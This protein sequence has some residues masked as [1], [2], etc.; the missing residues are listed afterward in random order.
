MQDHQLFAKFSKCD[1]FKDKIQYLGHVVTKEGI[2]VDPKK[3]RAIKDVTDVL[4]FMGITGYYRRF[5]EGFSRIANSI[6]S[7]QKKG[8]KFEWNQKCEESFK[9]LKTLLTN[10]PILRIADPNKEFL[11]STDAYNDGLGSVLNQEGHVIA[12]E[13]RK[14]KIHE[15]N[16]ATYDL[17]LVAVI[18]ALKMWLHHL[19]GRKFI[20]MTDNK[21]LKYMLD[22]PNLNARQARWIAFLSMI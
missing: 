10:A 19:I 3:I 13:S 15:N 4:S 17:E 11:V 14:L 2:S 9:K 18:H 7:L 21:G 12:Y 8:N 6:T 16:Y 20:L 1:F 22:Q 5:I